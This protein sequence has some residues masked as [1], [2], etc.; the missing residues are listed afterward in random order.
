MTHLLGPAARLVTI[1]VP[2]RHTCNIE[3][4]HR[5]HI[6]VRGC[7]YPVFLF[8]FFHL[9]VLFSYSSLWAYFC[10]V[11]YCFWSV[12]VCKTTTNHCW[13][14]FEW[15]KAFTIG[16]FGIYVLFGVGQRK[17]DW[18]RTLGLRDN[19]TLTNWMWKMR[20]W[21]WWGNAAATT[22]KINRPQPVKR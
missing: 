15:K 22:T 7:R 9:F 11:L 18:I 4:I 10:F 20:R 21:W 8:C 5:G 19:R 16:F 17:K 12:E 3:T 13:W 6:L 1:F 2:E 14:Y